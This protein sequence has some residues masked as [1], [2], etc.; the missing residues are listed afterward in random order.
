MYWIRKILHDNL[1]CRHGWPLLR[2]GVCES[3]TQVH[4]Y[5]IK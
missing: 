3:V 2:K 1:C 4:Y 5:N